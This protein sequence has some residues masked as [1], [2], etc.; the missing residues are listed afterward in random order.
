[1]VPEVG[2]G[3]CYLI[4]N[5]VGCCFLLV[6]WHKGSVRRRQAS[7]GLFFERSSTHHRIPRRNR[8]IS[9]L[10]LQHT[11][12]CLFSEGSSR[13]KSVRHPAHA[14]SGKSSLKR[15]LTRYYSQAHVAFL[16]LRYVA[17]LRLGQRILG[18]AQLMD[19]KEME[20]LGSRGL[21]V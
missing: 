4:A 15:L 20:L 19:R 13:R 18:G 21:A 6:Q 9:P 8:Q 1:M 5:E 7:P 17:R 3:K 11:S 2:N 16:R 14:D 10:P 12:Q